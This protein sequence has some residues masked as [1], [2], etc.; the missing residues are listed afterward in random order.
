MYFNLLKTFKYNF[1]D[2]W[3]EFNGANNQMVEPFI[4]PPRLPGIGM[5]MNGQIHKSPLNRPPLLLENDIS[6]FLIVISLF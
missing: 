1:L 3:Q 2:C 6:E 4:S 5:P